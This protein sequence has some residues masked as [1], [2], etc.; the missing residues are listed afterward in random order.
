MTSPDQTADALQRLEEQL[1]L[2]YV[3]GNLQ[4][5]SENLQQLLQ[6]TNER[7]RA[8]IEQEHDRTF[9]TIIKNHGN[10]AQQVDKLRAEDQE[11]LPALDSLRQQVDQFANNIDETVLARQQ[12]EAKRER[13][14]S[15][16]LAF[17]IRVRKQRAAID[18]WLGEALQRDNGVGD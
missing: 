17:V 4:S 11:L 9:K 13:L 12:F 18:T 8:E 5:W 3:S 6:E 16:A 14:V 10:L 15:D 1:E 7:L 2:P